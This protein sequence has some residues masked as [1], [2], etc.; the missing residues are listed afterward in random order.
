M[1]QILVTLNA[2]GNNRGSEALITGFTTI[3]KKKYKDCRIVLASKYY[4]NN[5]PEC[6]IEEIDRCIYK[7]YRGSKYS[8]RNVLLK[9]FR[10]LKLGYLHDRLYF[11]QLIR[12]VKKSDYVVVVGADN[13]DKSYNNEKELEHING[14]ICKYSKD[15]TIMYDCSFGKNDLSVSSIKDI[16]RF[17]IVT[18]RETASYNNVKDKIDTKLDLYPDP[19]FV[20]G[21]EKINLK[22]MPFENNY[23][24]I[25]LSNL[26]VQGNYVSNTDIIVENYRELVDKI[27]ENTD[28]N[29][30]F[31]PHVMGGNDLSVL[32][33]LYRGFEKNERVYLMENETLNAKQLKYIISKGRFV[34]TARTHASIA[35]YSLKIPTL[36]VGY[37][38][39]SLGIAEDLFG[40]SKN[41]VIS[42]DEIKDKADI[43]TKFEWFIENELEIREKMEKIIPPYIDKAWDT[44]K[45]FQ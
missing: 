3:C 45:I 28:M 11:C 38:I 37:S 32:K 23:I 7:G 35:A 18:C 39:K 31:L 9:M 41:Y 44:I 29:I 19:A 13:Y 10:L 21:V 14:L 36:V 43:Y 40:D 22:D 16:S 42:L 24:C 17:D 20:M 25:N 6:N 8:V 1:K 5:I 2:I 4:A 15:K 12:E 33:D 34:I 26:V 30:L 27:L